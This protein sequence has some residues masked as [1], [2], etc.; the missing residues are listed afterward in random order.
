MQ[1]RVRHGDG[2]GREAR[3]IT[4]REIA[5]TMSLEF[6][7]LMVST[8]LCALSVSII[9]LTW[10]WIGTCGEEGRRAQARR[11]RRGLRKA[12]PAADRPHLARQSPAHHRDPE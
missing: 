2:K 11:H 12:G 3:P 4:L 9:V 5:A 6:R 1:V 7:K 10:V 8:S